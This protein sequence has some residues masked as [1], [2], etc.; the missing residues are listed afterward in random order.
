LKSHLK[1]VLF[2]FSQIQ[3]KAEPLKLKEKKEFPLSQEEF[4][5]L[6]IPA[7][8]AVLVVIATAV[9]SKSFNPPSGVADTLGQ[10]VVDAKEASPPTME[11]ELFDWGGAVIRLMRNF[12]P[13]RLLT[14]R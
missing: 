8:V 5:S 2:T 4:N 13:H 1:K 10:M 11:R 6:V 3:A 14:R 12:G 9:Y 7:T